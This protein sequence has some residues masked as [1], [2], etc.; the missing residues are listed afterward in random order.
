[1]CNRPPRKILGATCWL[2]AVCVALW[3][4]GIYQHTRYKGSPPSLPTRAN[5]RTRDCCCVLLFHIHKQRQ[6]PFPLGSE[7]SPPPPTNPRRAQ[8]KEL[9]AFPALQHHPERI[10]S[11][12]LSPVLEDSLHIGGLDQVRASQGREP[13]DCV[14]V[15]TAYLRPNAVSCMSYRLVLPMS[16]VPLEARWVCRVSL[17]NTPLRLASTSNSCSLWSSSEHS[18]TCLYY[19]IGLC[20][21]ERERPWQLSQGDK[22][23]E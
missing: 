10:T 6:E 8:K 2:L 13:V 19:S 1:M 18:V 17:S 12:A 16:C 22:R 4:T 14:G 9:L 20:W 23:T 5:T 15:A 11:S 21:C 7:T 3:S